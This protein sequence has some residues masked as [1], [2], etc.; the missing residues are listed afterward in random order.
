MR[1]KTPISGRIVTDE[2]TKIIHKLWVG[3]YVA[4]WN[5]STKIKYIARKN[6]KMLP[7]AAEFS[8]TKKNKANKLNYSQKYLA[9]I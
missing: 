4:I 5:L 6:M 9:Y 7:N 2:K 3:D 8:Y 1:L